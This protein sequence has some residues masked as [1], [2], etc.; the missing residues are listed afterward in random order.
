[1]QGFI[2]LLLGA[3]VTNSARALLITRFAW[4]YL[5]YN[6]DSQQ[7]KN[8]F[9]QN[10]LYDYRN[11]TPIDVDQSADGR[12]FVTIIRAPGV[13]ASVHTVSSRNGPGGPLLK[14][15]PDWS[16]Y[17]NQCSGITSV[18]RVAIDKCNRIWI[19]DTGM[20]GDDHV[21][22]AQLLVFDLATN[23]LIHRQTIP[24]QIAR[25][26]NGAGR[27][28]TPI[29]EL[30]GNNCNQFNVYIADVTGHALIVWN[31]REFRRIEGD[32]FQPEPQNSQYSIAGESFY[33]ADGILGMSIS[34]W[35]KL[36]DRF[37][38]FKPLASKS[39]YLTTTKEI[40]NNFN[41]PQNIQYIRGRYVL[42]SQAS[43]MA[44]SSTGVLFF[45]MTREIGVGCYNIENPLVSQNMQS[46]ITD[47][48]RLQFISGMKV[49][50]HTPDPKNDKLVMMSNRLQKIYAGTMDF[51]DVNFR[52][53]LAPVNQLIKGSICDPNFTPYRSKN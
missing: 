4:K 25:N 24:D 52:I 48:D 18:Y 8:Y 31:G 30:D 9:V 20:I 3:H 2:W 49:I 42:P 40:Q 53:T 7:R 33:L 46:V 15:Y 35:T 21:C 16:W 10:G 44:F 14:P 23:K 47:Y 22:P 36:G 29:V 39:M 27:L 32:V 41:N 51:R 26:R 43:A 12:V 17:N 38:A 11:L 1:M 19:L 45:G 28:I 13:P 50:N 34:P 5:D 37:L 6:W